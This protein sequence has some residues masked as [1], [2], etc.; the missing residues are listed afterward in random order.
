MGRGTGRRRGGRGLARAAAGRGGG[1]LARPGGSRVRGRRAFRVLAGTLIAL[2]FV[3]MASA[4][5]R[6]YL[7]T[8]EYGLTE[9]RLYATI[10]MGWLAVVLV[11]FLL[12]V[13]RGRRDR[14]A[15][16]ALLSGFAVVFVV[17]AMNPDALIARTNL[18]RLEEGKRF[19]A[20]YLTTLSADA[21]PVLFDALP[22]ISEKCVVPEADLTVEEVILD[23]YREDEEGDWRTW[24]LSRS[25]ARHLAETYADPAQTPA[26]AG[27]GSDLEVNSM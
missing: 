14:F 2:L 17:N 4:L 15:F 9:L 21:A 27:T 22:E 7:Y 13:L 12:T 5:Q 8:E 26:K 20:F 19:D 10:F 23:R 24:N 18:E 25:R 1:A 16:G 11:W 3:V 6:M